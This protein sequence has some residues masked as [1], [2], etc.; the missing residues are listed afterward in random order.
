M[1]NTTQPLVSIITPCYNGEHCLFRLLDSI[2]AQSYGPIEFILVND[3]S[4][5]GTQALAES[6]ISK[7]KEAGIGYTIVCQE[8]KGLAGAINAGLK[9]FTGDYLEDRVRVLEEHTEY[10]V[11]SS[12]AFIRDSESLDTY[13]TLISSNRQYLDDP[14][15]F[16]HHL[17]GDSIFCSGCH[18]VRTSAFLEVHPN[19]M[20]YAARR[21]QNWQ[22]LLPLYYKYKWVFIDNPLYNYI[23]FP[24]SMSRDEQTLDALLFRYDEH[25]T[26]LNETLNQIER[27]QQADMGVYYAFVQDKYAKLRMTAAIQYR[28]KELFKKEFI[29]KQQTTGIDK[30]DRLLYWRYRI[31]VFNQVLKIVSRVIRNTIQPDQDN[32]GNRLFKR[33]GKG[34]LGKNAMRFLFLL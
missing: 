22:M 29:R 34:I 15:Q 20:I 18:M 17:N 9:R 16:M 6:Y 21:G 3:G 13:K 8:N 5:D 28:D 26:I 11:V 12:D 2:L 1:A 32:A 31:P 30:S 23:V 19:R 33:I 7:F 27:V 4:T 24:N 10:A 25:E 14:N